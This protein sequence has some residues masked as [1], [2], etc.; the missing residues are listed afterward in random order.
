VFAI[1]PPL[2]SELVEGS[3]T[4]VLAVAVLQLLS[5]QAEKTAMRPSLKRA[6]P[7]PQSGRDSDWYP[8]HF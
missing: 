5:A 6:A 7:L 4:Q 2:D 1:G 8:S 3:K